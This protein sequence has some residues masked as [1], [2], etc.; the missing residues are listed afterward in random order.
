MSVSH[1][2]GLEIAGSCFRL[3]EVQ[4]QDH[5]TVVLRADVYDTGADFASARMFDLPFDRQLAK[6][7][8]A[9]LLNALTASA[10]Y[11]PAVSLVLPSDLPLVATLPLDVSV[12]EQER[13]AL[14]EW[15]CR[16]LMGFAEGTPMSVLAHPI[17]RD[18]SHSSV[19][20]VALPQP[21]VDFL[22]TVFAH[23]TFDLASI[24]VDH[25]VMENLVRMQYP[26]YTA[27]GLAVVGLY[28]SHC[29]AGIYHGSVYSGFRLGTVSYRQQYASQALRLIEDL[30]GRQLDNVYCFGPGYTTHIGEALGGLLSAHVS[31][32]MPITD[33]GAEEVF[34]KN[35]NAAGEHMFD[36]A[37]AAAMLGLG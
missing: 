14:L 31:R 19:L 36:V 35:G 4:R 10:M 29:S 28:A 18:E 27:D 9:D 37:A 21:L 17:R 26:K 15:E 12:P 23:L 3:V 30:S 25:F 2:I 6:T 1:H 22:N 11:S 34:R 24:D 5:H 20:V 33:P 13:M 8:I 32:C 7:F 16:T